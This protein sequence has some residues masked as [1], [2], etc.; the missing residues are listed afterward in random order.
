M[1]LLGNIPESPSM[2]ERSRHDSPQSDVPLPRPSTRAGIPGK[3]SDRVDHGPALD[4]EPQ[5]RLRL[6]FPGPPDLDAD[7]EPLRH[8]S[9]PDP[10]PPAAA[11]WRQGIPQAA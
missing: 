11:P 6:A 5:R 2:I 3:H 8:L 4:L 10:G 7:Q 9:R 1:A